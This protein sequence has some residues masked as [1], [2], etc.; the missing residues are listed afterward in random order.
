MTGISS[1]SA[2]IS[3][4]AEAASSARIAAW[5][6]V[7]PEHGPIE[8]PRGRYRVWKQR[9]WHGGQIRDVVD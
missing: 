6:V 4:I 2:W 1:P 3:P 7:H 5:R 9:E 8:L